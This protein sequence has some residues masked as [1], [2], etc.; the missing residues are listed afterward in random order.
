MP[1]PETE[2]QRTERIL[3]ELL[4]E[5]QAAQGEQAKPRRRFRLPAVLAGKIERKRPAA[6]SEPAKPR[7]RFQLPAV[8]AGQ[9]EKKRPAAKSEPAEPRRRFQLPAVPTGRVERK[10]PAVQGEPAEPRGRFQLP[11]VPVGKAERKQQ[12]ATTSSRLE[13]LPHHEWP[14]PPPA[15]FPKPSEK[16]DR[17]SDIVVAGLGVTLGLICALF[18]WY[19]FFNDIRFSTHGLR[20]GGNGDR[21]GRIVNPNPAAGHV[22]PETA[23]DEVPKNLDLFATGTPAEGPED[24]EDA[25]GIDQQPFPADTNYRLVHVANGRAMIEDDAGLWVVQPGST[26]PDDTKLTAIEKR[27]SKWVLVTSANTIVELSP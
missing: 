27:G 1:I 4:A 19:I 15:Q 10:R 12:P 14:Q 18:P 2:R 11:A 22:L 5:A 23:Q 7:R 16:P 9:I 26:L 21:N 13:A 17:R 3:R 24:P 20:V 8:L 25:P 6:K